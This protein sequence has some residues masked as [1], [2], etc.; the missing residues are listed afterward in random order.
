MPDE[1]VGE[2]RA[3]NPQR[4]RF[5]TSKPLAEVGHKPPRR[6]LRELIKSRRLAVAAGAGGAAALALMGTGQVGNAARAGG[7]LAAD[8]VHGTDAALGR[9][10]DEINT[11]IPVNEGEGHVRDNPPEELRTTIGPSY[12]ETAN[13]A[14]IPYRYDAKIQ[15]SGNEPAKIYKKPDIGSGVLSTEE[16][17]KHGIALTNGAKVEA[18]KWKGTR[19]P[20]D[21]KAGDEGD[22]AR[23][24]NTKGD[25]IGFTPD[26]DIEYVPGSQKLIFDPTNPTK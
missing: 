25:E 15:F 5:A 26:T 9:V 8:V 16:L 19:Y 6:S 24:F 13:G 7:E 20:S 12:F 17:G 10:S 22:W 1:V 3:G 21:K 2:R 4:P 23:I 11:I 18:E 14:K